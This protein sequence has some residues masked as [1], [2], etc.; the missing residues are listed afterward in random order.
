MDGRA[1][2]IFIGLGAF[3]PLLLIGSWVAFVL[4]QM[5]TM[6]TADRAAALSSILAQN[7]LVFL[8][9]LVVL[10][11]RTRVVEHFIGLDRM[12]RTHRPLALLTF[13]LLLCHVAFQGVRFYALG[14]K[15]LALS[16]LVG[17]TVWEMTVGRMS[18]LLVL[19][20]AMAALSGKILRV[21]FIL[22]K[23]LHGLAYGAVPLAFAHALFRGTTMGEGLRFGVWLVLL[24]IFLGVS[25]GR[26][27]KILRGSR[28]LCQVEQ[29]VPETHD[30]VSVWLRP[31]KETGKLAPR[32]AG[33][34]ALLRLATKRGFSEPHPF[35][36]SGPPED[37][38]LR[39]TIKRTGSFTQRIHRLSS[40][41]RILYEGPFGVFLADVN[42]YSSLALI[43]GGVGITPFLS[44]LRHFQ[45]TSQAVPTVL[46]YANKTL[47]DII[48]REE[49]SAMAQTMPLQVVHVL[50]RETFPNGYPEDGPRVLFLKGHIT[51]EILKS[52]L[53]AD[54]GF[55]L[56]GP[57]AMQQT[58]LKEIR[59]AFGLKPSS[60]SRELFFW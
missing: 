49:L 50:S 60:V 40:G 46:L 10:G 36:I 12:I 34:F 23:P 47:K 11:S 48:A 59:A 3:L 32:R 13:G 6:G 8:V 44:L 29:I 19:L 7:G 55:Y 52:Q 31:L 18:L 45:V 38:V 5:G 1:V 51:A 16:A 4:P 28:I 56:C 33:Q 26:L 37:Q 54:Q 22:W 15:D 30:T 17:S 58:V 53:Q 43:A 20:V 42:R 21:P 24:S 14:G 2:K 27:I 35:T 9:V 39:F 57:P 25:L 41:D